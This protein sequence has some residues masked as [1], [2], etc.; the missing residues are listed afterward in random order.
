MDAIVAEKVM[1]I[2][3]T[4]RWLSRLYYDPGGGVRRALPRYSTDFAAAFEVVEKMGERGFW[5]RMTTPFYPGA[6]YH[7]GFTPHE[8]TG[9][10]GRPDH[11]GS[12]PTLA[13]AICLAALRALGVEP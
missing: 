5:C 10:N 1:G 6:P 12:A 8:T 7:A 13:H 4:G 3:V 2:S 11:E 9:W